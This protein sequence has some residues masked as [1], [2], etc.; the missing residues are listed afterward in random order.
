[1]AEAVRTTAAND[2]L[3]GIAL[4]IGVDSGRPA[5]AERIIDDLIDCCNRLATMASH[6][7][8]GTRAPCL[9]EGIRLFSHRRWVIIF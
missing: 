9:G 3:R 6:A 5:A 4:Q 8:L 1:M 2:D 7:R